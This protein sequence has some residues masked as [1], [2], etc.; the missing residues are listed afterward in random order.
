MVVVL[1]PHQRYV[2]QSLCIVYILIIFNSTSKQDRKLICRQDQNSQFCENGHVLS[3]E[4]VLYIASLMR[5]LR[6]DIQNTDNVS[7]DNNQSTVLTMQLSDNNVLDILMFAVVGK[8]VSGDV[9]D[10]WGSENDIRYDSR[11]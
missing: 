11:T 2:N 9:N 3:T 1:S 7:T 4:S 6:T 10:I 5:W 8:L